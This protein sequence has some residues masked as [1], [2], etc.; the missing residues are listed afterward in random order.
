DVDWVY[1]E[2]LSTSDIALETYG[3][4]LDDTIL[5]LFES[6]GSTLITYDDD[7]NYDFYSL[8]T[9]EGLAAGTYYA[10]VE[11]YDNDNEILSYTLE[12]T[13]G[14]I[15]GPDSYEPDDDYS[16]ATLIE[17]GISQ[18]HSISPADDWDW[19]YFTLTSAADIVL[20]TEGLSG[21]DTILYLFEPVGWTIVDYDDDGGFDLYSRLE[22]AN[23]DSGTYYAL[24]EE[25]D[26]DEEIPSYTLELTVSSVG[27][28]GDSYEPDDTSAQATTITSGT[29][30]SHS[31]APV[32][33]VDWVTFTLS[34]T[35]DIILETSGSAD[36]DTI[37]YL[38]ESDGTTQVTYDD[39]GGSDFYSR[40]TCDD[41]AAGTYYAIVE[42]YFSNDEIESYSIELSVVTAGAGDAFEPDDTSAEASTISHGVAQ[43]H[44][45]SPVGDV[46]WVK[47]TLSSTADIILETSS[48]VSGDTVIY[49]C[50]SDGV[51]LITWDDDGGFAL[52]SRLTYDDL[53][54]GTYYAMVE[55]YS[56]TEEIQSYTLE[57]TI[58]S[59]SEGTDSYEP[60]DT[61]AQAS[62]ISDGV[63]QEHSI[64]PVGDVDWVKFTIDKVSDV[65]L[66]TSGAGYQDTV[67]Y[68]YESDGT[69]QIS[70]DDDGGENLF[71]RLAVEGLVA[72]TYYAYVVEYNNDEEIPFY[73]LLLTV[74]TRE[75][76][77]YPDSYEPDD[78]HSQATILPP[79]T[80]QSHSIY[81]IGDIDWIKF[82][83]SSASS[84]MIET[85]G[86]TQADTVLYLYGS[87]GTTLIGSDDD[88]GI[89]F[90][91]K[92]TATGLAAGTYYAKIEDYS[93]DDT[94]SEYSITLTLD[95]SK[96]ATSLNVRN[97]NAQAGSSVELHAQLTL[98][99]GTP[100]SGK[101]IQFSVNGETGSS[102]TDT[103]GN[104][105]WTLNVPSGWSGQYT[106]TATFAGDASLLEA[107]G[108]SDLT[109]GDVTILHGTIKFDLTVSLQ[110]DADNSFFTPFV[111]GL[112]SATNYLWDATEGQFWI[113]QITIYENSEHWDT[114]DIRV[115]NSAYHPC[116]YVGGIERSDQHIYIGLGWSGQSSTDPNTW[117]TADGY[118][119][120][121]HELGHYAL[122]LYDEYLDANEQSL[123]NSQIMR[124][125]MGYQYDTEVTEFSTALDYSNP[126]SGASANTY[127]W[128]YYGKSCWDVISDK[129][130]GIT[131]PTQ[132]GLPGPTDDVGADTEIILPAGTLECELTKD[133]DGDGIP[134]V[135]DN[136]PK[137]PNE[138]IDSDND[139]IGDKSDSDSDNDGYKDNIEIA[140]GT[141]PNDP[142]EK[143][144]DIDSDFI[145]DEMDDDD[146]GDG[147]SDKVEEALGRDP[148]NATDYPTAPQITHTLP[149]G[150]FIAG[151]T[152]NLSV[153]IDDRDDDINFTRSGIYYS[154]DN[155]TTWNFLPFTDRS[156][157]MFNVSITPPVGTYSLWYYFF[158]V[159]SLG[160]NSTDPLDAPASKHVLTLQAAA[161]DG[162]GDGEEEDDKEDGPPWLWIG[163]II[164]VVVVVIVGVI[165]G[166]KMAGK[167][168][169]PKEP[170]EG[171]GEPVDRFEEPKTQLEDS[172]EPISPEKENEG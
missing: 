33:D 19:V 74:T 92:I 146:D 31:I 64:S 71:S 126:P 85:K 154:F 91:S 164:I 99:D 119:T 50:A 2:L 114:A 6:D 5:Y 152:I 157:G 102:S 160:L 55:E 58:S 144:M 38:I 56:Y 168:K 60:D 35:A 69:T 94:I 143:P 36:G 47:F 63:A 65:V 116:A 151:N 108:N 101:T 118:R 134:D 161:E 9:I 45:I 23:L 140:L 148:K 125:V 123:P 77:G 83:L 37:L 142:K 1:F 29:P 76:E 93:G 81:P 150:T 145:P 128:A 138:M 28:T 14:G 49:L 80:R 165:S 171:I 111:S 53:G 20:E 27:V 122:Y 41:L 24:I 106:I 42:E 155:G 3:D 78:I 75:C 82:T 103:N 32:G 26:N 25:Y 79:D 141:N 34:S 167:G 124:R 170:T 136:F 135:S 109:V 97:A 115:H 17:D 107:S 96:L 11:E 131:V 113:R 120:I 86:T 90:Y 156:E 98:T 18:D 21:G 166:K 40:L 59:I 52:F 72:G 127:H 133:S 68:L 112:R 159:D 88:G 121:I 62:T 110:W 16:E 8:I 158:L 73:E 15:G 57:L 149:S 70:S 105:Y 95:S 30:Q 129:Y 117:A 51:T 84:V 67:M 104:A 89:D 39:D 12:L 48:A 153:G 43:E 137:N 87:D 162:D 132:R 46:D 4:E 13:V 163:A 61:S 10:V 22:M 66:E 147:F 44:S 54:A 130:S 139:G 100:L 169:P 172:K 7:G